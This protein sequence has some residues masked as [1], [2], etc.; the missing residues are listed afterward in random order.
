MT[1]GKLDETTE[2]YGDEGEMWCCTFLMTFSRVFKYLTVHLVESLGKHYTVRSERLRK[3]SL[4]S[5]FAGD[6]NLFPMKGNALDKSMLKLHYAKTKYA[7]FV[8]LS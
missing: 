5:H 4:K 7:M 8:K 2:K 6:K 1:V 3:C